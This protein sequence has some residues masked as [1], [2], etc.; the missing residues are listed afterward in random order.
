MLD[1]NHYISTG[2]SIAAI[3]GLWYKLKNDS[4]KKHQDLKDDQEEKYINLIADQD[5]KHSEIKEKQTEML[6]N[7]A[8]MNEIQK[9]HYG[10]IKS[11]FN[12]KDE[13]VQKQV[14]DEKHKQ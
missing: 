6:V 3:F 2:A 10:M 1:F 9:N 13:F 4:N 14:C 7:M 12:H 5:F 11:L 8:S